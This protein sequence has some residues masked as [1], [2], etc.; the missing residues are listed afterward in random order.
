MAQHYNPKLDEIPLVSSRL[1]DAV[2]ELV[3]LCDDQDREVRCRTV[4]LFS[5]IRTKQIEECV[6]RLLKDEDELVRVACLEVLGDWEDAMFEDEVLS[7][8]KDSSELVRSAAIVAIAHIGICGAIDVLISMLETSENEEE[9]RIYYALCQL[10]KSEYFPLFLNGLYDSFYRIRC[11]TTNLLTNLIT[12]FNKKLVL[13][14]LSERV[15]AEE[16]RAAKT[17]MESAISYINELEF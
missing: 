16:S 12:E 6:C 14:M 1:W 13:S 15:L 8:L 11:A 7:M 5:D 17:T 3:T 2:R 9:V 4:E 10:G